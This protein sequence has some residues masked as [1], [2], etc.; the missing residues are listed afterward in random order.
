MAV[1]V[2]SSALELTIGLRVRKEDDDWA[3]GQSSL[4]TSILKVL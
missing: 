1:S 4:A 3:L 2:D